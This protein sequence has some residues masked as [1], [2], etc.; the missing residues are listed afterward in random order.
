MLNIRYR[1]VKR[2]VELGENAQIDATEA[3]IA[4]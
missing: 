3:R 2:G 4:V 1:G